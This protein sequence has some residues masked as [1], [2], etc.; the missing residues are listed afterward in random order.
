MSTIPKW[1]VCDI[2][3]PRYTHIIECSHEHHQAPRST[4]INQ[5]DTYELILCRSQV[6]VQKPLLV[7]MVPEGFGYPS[8]GGMINMNVLRV[9]R[10]S[11]SP[12]FN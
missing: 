1:V 6:S 5:L 8:L 10:F 11:G 7:K 2:V 4:S 9:L 3:I 12:V